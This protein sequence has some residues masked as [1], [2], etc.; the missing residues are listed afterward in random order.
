MSVKKSVSGDRHAQLYNDFRIVFT[1]MPTG[2]TTDF[3]AILSK[4]DDKYT[5]NWDTVESYGR[6][7]PVATFKNTQRQISFSIDVVSDDSYEAALNM[8]RYQKLTRFLYPK[9]DSP[10]AGESMDGGA[11]TIASA[12]LIGI[13][14]GNLMQDHATGGN[15]VGY[16]D[17]FNFAPDDEV[18]WWYAMG[19]DNTSLQTIDKQTLKSDEKAYKE[20]KQSGLIDMDDQVQYEALPP[21]LNELRSVEGPILL[22]RKFSISCNFH[23]LHTHPVGWTSWGQWTEAAGDYPY[24]AE[25]LTDAMPPY[26]AEQAVIASHA[27]YVE[28]KVPLSVK[29]DLLSALFGF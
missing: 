21:A 26:L 20:A 6:M 23:V 18:G 15:L 7:D 2:K 10:L 29:N 25:S 24:G 19:M 12:P 16:V 4:F 5:S 8:E 13:K 22:A 3:A 17:G 14:F 1:H 28:A 11:V 27:S 9:Y